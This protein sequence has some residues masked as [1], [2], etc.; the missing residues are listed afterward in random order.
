MKASIIQTVRTT[1]E[2][3][4]HLNNEDLI[5]AINQE[6]KSQGAAV[7]PPEAEIYFSVPGGGDWSNTDIDIDDQCPIKIKW[8][9]VTEE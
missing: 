2:R 9:E 7:I 1:V 6:L 3:E 8:T 4:I 5:L